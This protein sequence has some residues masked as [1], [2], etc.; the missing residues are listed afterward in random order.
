MG[1][2]TNMNRANAFKALEDHFRYCKKPS[3]RE[4]IG[5]RFYSRRSQ[6]P[7]ANNC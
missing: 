6:K 7:K 2:C 4:G 3:L 5:P 1:N